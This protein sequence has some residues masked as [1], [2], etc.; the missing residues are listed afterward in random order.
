MW[1]KNFKKK[2]KKLLHSHGKRSKFLGL[3]GWVKNLMITLVSSCFS[4]WANILHPSV[5]TIYLYDILAKD[6]KFNLKPPSSLEEIIEFIQKYKERTKCLK[7]DNSEYRIPWIQKPFKIEYP[8][9][10]LCLV[11]LHVP[12]YSGLVQIFVPDKKMICIQ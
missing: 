12:T 8:S 1:K 2:K 9:S 7:K 10:H 11:P 6:E 4:P 3:Q 5:Q